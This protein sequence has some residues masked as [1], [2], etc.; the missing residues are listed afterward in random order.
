MEV[1]LGIR[2]LIF[3]AL[4]Q[5]MKGRLSKKGNQTF[6]E[7]SE[8]QINIE[9]SFKSWT[10]ILVFGLFNSLIIFLIEMLFKLKRPR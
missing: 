4:T 2:S 5:Q 6:T 7:D 8:F 1:G 9:D 3:Y 10:P